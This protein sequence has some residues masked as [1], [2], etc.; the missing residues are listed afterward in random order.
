MVNMKNNTDYMKGKEN[1][2]ETDLKTVETLI[3]NGADLKKEYNIDFF[4]VGEK[5]DLD[6]LA[7]TLVEQGYKISKDQK[8]GELHVDQD[9]KLELMKSLLITESLESLALENG[10]RFDGWGT[11]AN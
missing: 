3:K 7:Q 2:K 11:V 8:E 10:A 4:F 9:I 6:K 5:D 1:R